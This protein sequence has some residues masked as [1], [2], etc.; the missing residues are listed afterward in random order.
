[1]YSHPHSHDDDF[2]FEQQR[3]PS[4]RWFCPAEEVIPSV[5]RDDSLSAIAHDA[6]QLFRRMVRLA[7]KNLK[8]PV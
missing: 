6:I 7:V 1:M 4:D 3:D 2:L 8:Y 5:R